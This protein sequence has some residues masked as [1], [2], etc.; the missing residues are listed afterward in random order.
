MCGE[1][2]RVRVRVAAHWGSSPRVR[3]KPGQ[4]H[5]EGQR[6]RL[7]PARAGKTYR[8]HEHFTRNRAHPRACGENG[9]SSSG[10]ARPPWLIPAR[11]GK[12]D[13]VHPALFV[14]RAHP[15]ACGENRSR[16]ASTRASS[17]SSPRVRGKRTRAGRGRRPRGLI[18]A[19]AGKTRTAARTHSPW[20]AHPRACGENHD[21]R[22][23]VIAPSGSSPR[24]RGKLARLR[25]SR[26]GARLIPARAGKTGSGGGRCGAVRAHPRACGENGRIGVPVSLA[27]GSS[28]RVRGKRQVAEGRTPSHGLIPARA[29]KTLAW[30]F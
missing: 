16:T 26:A 3:G 13:A 24:V 5:A 9:R 17:G 2:W 12:T 18:P 4:W 1:N 22:G 11:A 28:P 21:P 23:V 19:R 14:R 27:S 6:G 29:G 15:R 30:F 7:I 8:S 25:R 20:T 10:H